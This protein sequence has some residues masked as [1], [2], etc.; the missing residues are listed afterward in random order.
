MNSDVTTDATLDV[1]AC[2]DMCVTH[3]PGA[4]KKDEKI[5]EIKETEEVRADF[6]LT[7]HQHVHCYCVHLSLPTRE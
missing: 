2:T 6:L 4:I 7:S 5:N 3:V 1:G